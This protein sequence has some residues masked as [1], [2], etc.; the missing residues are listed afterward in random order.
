[1]RRCNQKEVHAIEWEKKVK[2]TF[3]RLSLLIG[4]A[5]F[6]LAS[7]SF[8]D[9]ERIEL[10]SGA[11]QGLQIEYPTS[12]SNGAS[13]GF[14]SV[15][16]TV[17]VT[18]NAPAAGDYDIT[19]GYATE[20][21]YGYV[22]FYANDIEI[23][24]STKVALLNTGGWT[25][26]VKCPEVITAALN[27]GPNEIKIEIVYEACNLDYIDIHPAV[28]RTKYEVEHAELY[29]T[30]FVTDSDQY[31][32]I[33]KVGFGSTDTATF[34]V[35]VASAGKYHLSLRTSGK[36]PARQIFIKVN[37]VEKFSGTVQHASSWAI[38]SFTP[39]LSIDLAK[40]DNTIVIGTVGTYGPNVD[41]MLISEIDGLIYTPA[42]G[43]EVVLTGTELSWTVGD[44]SGV[45][46]YQVV[47][48]AT[49]ELI[50]V[51]V[52]GNGSYSVTLPEGV[53]AKLVVVDNSGFSQTFLPADGNIVKVVY[54]LK[55]GWNLIAMPGDNA[56]TTDLQKA[57]AGDFWAWNGS[58]YETTENPAAC[59]GIWVY[60]PKTV[61]AIVT[62]EKSDVDI[63]LQ[64][65]WNLVGPKENITVPETAH[66]VYSWNETYQEIADENAVLIQGI[67]YWIFTL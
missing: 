30:S 1:M 34:T 60:A 2:T 48:A 11:L 61:Q 27:A 54:D 25:S 3:K 36:S 58:A 29:S 10:E 45:K 42:I 43:L 59:Q 55:E 64:S 66:T 67:G 21:T 24:G 5:G 38:Y 37:D 57:T 40:G 4:V 13:L 18:Y 6:L 46:E 20:R 15:G 12:A 53:E 8:A 52:A 44:E 51:V 14:A 32:T 50:E 35:N 31:G 62:A 23:V 39:I 17:T 28:T 16:D 47:N 63:S 7:S 22:K 9:T 41:Y 26:W 56:E 33:T 65:G 49:G 19:L